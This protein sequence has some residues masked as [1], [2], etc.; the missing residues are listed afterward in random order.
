MTF[1]LTPA[2]RASLDRPFRMLI[3]GAWVEAAAGER[4]DVVNPADGKTIATIPAAQAADV[5]DA[6]AAARRAFEARRWSGLTPGARAS[7]LW[8][9]ADLLEARIDEF[10]ELET[11]DNGKPV[12]AARAMDIPAAAATF[13]YWAGWCTK[14]S[15]Q[16]PAVDLPGEYMAMTLKE[17][18]GVVGL[19]TP[20]NFPLVNAAMKLAPALAAACTIVLKPAEQTSLTALRLGELLQEAGVPA[21][22]VNIVTGLGRVAGAALA[23][24]PD[25]DK[26]SFTGSTTV[27]KEL[28]AAARG[29]LKRLTLEL[30][31]K[32]PTIILPDADLSRA[33]PAAANAIFRNAGQACAAGSR[34]LVAR[35]R[36]DEV[37]E[38][39][40]ALAGAHRLG[41]GLDPATTMGPLVSAL[42]QDRV[43]GY[44]ESARQDGATIAVGGGGHGSEGFFVEPTVIID[45]TASARVM[46]EEIFGPVLVATAFDD[47][48]HLAALANDTVYGLSAAIWSRDVSSAYRLARSVRAGTITVNSGMVVGPNLPFGGYKQSGWGREGGLEGLDAYLETKTIVTAI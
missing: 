1:S 12:T 21:G 25:V 28:I 34:L 43:L 20:W 18:V 29:N 31:G 17:P 40:A 35:E 33:A 38:A 46:R 5:D 39:V 15:G 48:D 32:S 45:P 3:D 41:P 8:R 16:T 36:F 13:R 24:H 6:V 11:L 44:V 23:G 30:G 19:I 10:A 37:I 47:V 14:I 26:V 4:L 27:G 42:Q 7:I 9:V 22:V 2:A